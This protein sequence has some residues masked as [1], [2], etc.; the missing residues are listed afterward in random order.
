MSING[1]T[2][3]QVNFFLLCLL[4]YKMVMDFNMICSSMINWIVKQFNRALIVKFENNRIHL[5]IA[6]I[7]KNSP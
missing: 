7:S 3:D 1:I 6:N 5:F 2:I 4:S